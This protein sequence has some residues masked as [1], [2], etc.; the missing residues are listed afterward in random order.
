VH[1]E[2]NI[3]SVERIS[4][5]ARIQA[6]DFEPGTLGRLSGDDIDL[7]DDIWR[8]VPLTGFSAASCLSSVLLGLNPLSAN[9]RNSSLRRAVSTK[10]WT[11]ILCV[12]MIVSY[13]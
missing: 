7:E 4:R 8:F 9:R 2:L 5:L 3:I 12:L 11:W 1:T 6:F 13:D 10:K